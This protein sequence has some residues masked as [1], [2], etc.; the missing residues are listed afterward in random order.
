[1]KCVASKSAFN[2]IISRPSFVMMGKLIKYSQIKVILNANQ[3][4]KELKSK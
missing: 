2:N 4:L 1:M 3:N